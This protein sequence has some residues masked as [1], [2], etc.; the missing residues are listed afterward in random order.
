MSNILKATEIKLSISWWQLFKTDLLGQV[1]YSGTK[2][3]FSPF[4]LNK[5]LSSQIILFWFFQFTCWQVDLSSCEHIRDFN[6]VFDEHVSQI[7]GEHVD[8]V[9]SEHV[10]RVTGE[11]VA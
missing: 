5:E 1:S 8:R 3:K 9:T 6:Q 4:S 2:P 10:G 7:T 11:N